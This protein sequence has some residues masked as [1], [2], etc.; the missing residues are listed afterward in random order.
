MRAQA[1]HLMGLILVLSLMVTA[2]GGAF[3]AGGGFAPLNPSFVQYQEQVKKGAPADSSRFGLRPAPLDLSHLAGKAAFPSAKGARAADPATYD[4]RTQSRV[5]P[6]RN[7]NPFGTCWTFGTYASLESSYTPTSFPDFSEYHLAYCAYTSV[8]GNPAFTR[9]AVG[10]GENPIFD[11]G[12]YLVQSSA[13]LARWTE[14]VNEADCPY[15]VSGQ[16]VP[17]GSE[18]VVAHV[19]NILYLGNDRQGDPVLNGS[20]V[21]YALQHYG[22][23][24][25]SM[26]WDDDAYKASTASYYNPDA[27]AGEGHIVA[28]V[29][30]NDDYPAANFAT[31]PGSNGAWLVKNSWGTAWGDG[32]YFWI[33][34]RDASINSPAVFL[35][36]P[37]TN[38][39]RNYQYDPLG[40]VNGYGYSSTTGYFAN[41][42]TAQGGEPLVAVSFYAGSA[43]AAYEIS[44]YTNVSGG[45]TS[46]VVALSGQAGTLTAAGYHTI[47][48]LIP[49]S[50]TTGQKF[51]VVVKLTTPGFNFPIPV[52]YA[53][54]NYSESA[55]AGAGQSYISPNGTVWTDT[56]TI[57]TTMN[58]CLK[59]FTGIAGP[60]TTPAATA[61]PTGSPTVTP[62]PSGGGGGGCDA[63]GLAPA[64]AFLAPILLVV[65]RRR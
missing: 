3:A 38:Y 56:T 58:V 55:S 27:E 42:F 60:T 34:Y 17:T 50:L 21:K 41:V 43:G 59:A 53:L 32:G 29:G 16:R 63:L 7:Q 44:V 31:N 30:W 49:V 36:E 2:V 39:T 13:L 52:E 40:W 4:L 5:T 22:A 18:S 46:G 8:G 10:A 26:N 11:Q 65:R 12:G 64:L 23:V 35:G 24:A 62:R 51:S 19:Q 15:D 28:I 1:K 54:A 33:S 6:V 48:L 20:D 25:I 47:P 61:T 9:Q 37:T 57:D 45:P 14:P